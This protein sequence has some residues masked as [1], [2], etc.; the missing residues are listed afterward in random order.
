MRGEARNI[1]LIVRDAQDSKQLVHRFYEKAPDWIRTPETYLA[2]VGRWTTVF[3]SKG[4]S[5]ISW[6]PRRYRT[7]NYFIDMAGAHMTNGS[8]DVDEMY[9]LLV[10]PTDVLPPNIEEVP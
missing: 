3:K 1:G 6:V 5:A 7:K 8:V 9:K 4:A 10:L 2:T